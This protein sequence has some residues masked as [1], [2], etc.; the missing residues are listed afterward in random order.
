MRGG[1]KGGER[2]KTARSRSA[3][4]ARWLSRQ[5]ADPTRVVE[6]RDGDVEESRRLLRLFNDASRH[7]LE[8]QAANAKVEG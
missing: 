8:W 5:L 4:S 3:S 7:A 6:V 1:P 2:L